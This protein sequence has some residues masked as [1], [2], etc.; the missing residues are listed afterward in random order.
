MI[1]IKTA[2]PSQDR[3]SIQ[4]IEGRDRGSSSLRYAEVEAPSKISTVVAQVKIFKNVSTVAVVV[5]RDLADRFRT[6]PWTR[7]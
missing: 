1:R 3:S 6:F 5:E 2:A 7:S 4:V